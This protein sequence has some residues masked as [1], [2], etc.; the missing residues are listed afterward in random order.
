[1]TMPKPAASCSACGVPVL[2]EQAGIVAGSRAS[3]PLTLC[4]DCVQRSEALFLSETEDA[5]LGSAIALGLGAGLLSALVWFAVVAL[6]G[7]QL[8]IVAVG[9]GWLV[10]QAVMLGSGGK[11]GGA[12]PWISMGVTV[13]AMLLSEYFIIRHFLVQ[14]LAEDEGIAG[15]PLVLPPGL[16]AELVIEGVKSEPLTVVFWAVAIIE[17]VGIPR[18]RRLTRV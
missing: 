16:I 8:G 13:L 2:P 7:Y 14:I 3:G 1:M 5:N 12:L 18:K 6:T 10:A 9:I 4:P 15:V 17:S 11:R